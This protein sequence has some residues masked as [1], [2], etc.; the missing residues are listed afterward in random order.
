MSLL[1]KR[2]VVGS[3]VSNIR[4]AIHKNMKYSQLFHDGSWVATEFEILAA[5]KVIS[6]SINDGISV[7]VDVGTS[8]GPIRSS[9]ALDSREDVLSLAHALILGNARIIRIVE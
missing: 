5:H 2:A 7:D 4:R 1:G 3:G 8:A 9:Y 6:P